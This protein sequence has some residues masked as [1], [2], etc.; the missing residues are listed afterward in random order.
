MLL[1]T[2]RYRLD[3]PLIVAQ[4]TLAFKC[5]WE[6]G[7]FFVGTT[8][9]SNKMKWINQCFIVGF[10]DSLLFVTGRD[11]FAGLILA[12]LPILQVSPILCVKYL[13][14]SFLSLIP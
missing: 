9:G 6:H 2:L 5:A 13:N 7:D 12:I 14:V 4:V 11:D 3:D 8:T 10:V 1:N